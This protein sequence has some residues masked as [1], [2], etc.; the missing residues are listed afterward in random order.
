MF[1]LQL[2]RLDSSG[3]LYDF[4]FEWSLSFSPRVLGLDC[5]FGSITYSF[6]DLLLLLPVVFDS[7]RVTFVSE[8]ATAL[9]Y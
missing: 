6:I 3:K 1:L 5:F 2:S 4:D 9:F 8:G 7:G